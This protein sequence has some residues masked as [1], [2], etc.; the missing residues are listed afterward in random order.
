MSK[1]CQGLCASSNESLNIHCLPNGKWDPDPDK[2][3]VCPSPFSTWPWIT[4]VATPDQSKNAAYF[5]NCNGNKLGNKITIKCRNGCWEEDKP[6]DCPNPEELW[7]D[8]NWT[9]GGGG[10]RNRT[11]NGICP[12]SGEGVKIYCQMGVWTFDK[13]CNG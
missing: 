6:C 9:S 8:F 2:K 3:L 11:Y 13:Y 1:Y 5:G 4:W 7:P 12:D 10:Q